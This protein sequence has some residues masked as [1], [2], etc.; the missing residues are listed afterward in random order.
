MHRPAQLIALRPNAIAPI[1]LAMVVALAIFAAAATPA[2]A[3]GP[4]PKHWF[5]AGVQRGAT[6]DVTVGGNFPKWPVGVW[7]DRSGLTVTPGEK[8]KLS[9]AA[10][11][12]AQPGVYWIRLYDADAAAPP[13]PFVV[14]TLTDVSEKE[15]NNAPTEA[16]S[17]DASVVV[18]GRLSSG[19]EVDTFAVALTKGQT[20]VASLMGHETLGSPFDAV[21]QIVAPQGNV[22]AYNHDHGGLDPQIVFV[23]PTDGNYLVRTFAFPSNPNS[24]IGFAGADTFVYRLTLTTGPFVDYVWPMAI[25]A[26]EESSVALHGWNLSEA[27]GAKTLVGAIPS[28]A[29]F[30]PRLANTIALAVEPHAA[31]AESDSEEAPLAIQLPITVTGRIAARGDQ[32][33]YTFDATKGEAF[34]FELASR[35][36]GYPLDGVLEV[37]DG[38]GKSLARVDDVGS[39]RDPVLAFTAP[40]DGTFRVTVSDLYGHGS[41]RHVYRLRATKVVPDFSVTTDQHA[42]VLVAGKPTE[43]TLS[44]ARQGGFAEPISF[45]V[46]G[47]PDFVTAAEATSAATGD[48]AKAVKLAL[49]SNGGAFSGPIRIVGEATGDSKQVHEASAAIPDHEARTSDVWLTT[50]GGD[51]Q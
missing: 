46:T 37:T 17:V 22:L 21:L 29:V 50:I 8:G 18:N 25:R 27:L 51:S 30:D 38:D 45:R 12:D 41:D 2:V 31:I 48:S 43:I 3:A 16:H 28:V 34:S 39:T 11:A 35:S 32:D 5:P 19:G 14:G 44:I 33:T 6:A 26:D 40:A 23:A 20:L 10:A 42:Y 13:R 24:T 7:V 4:E 36:L 49:T 47:L 15:P 1:A 9:I